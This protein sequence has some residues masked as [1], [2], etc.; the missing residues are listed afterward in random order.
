MA[1]LADEFG[2]LGVEYSDDLRD[3]GGNPHLHVVSTSTD[4]RFEFHQHLL[5]RPFSNWVASPAH[6]HDPTGNVEASS[7]DLATAPAAWTSHP[8]ASNLAIHGLHLPFCACAR[9]A[10]CVLHFFRTQLEVLTRTPK[11]GI[12]RDQAKTEPLWE[13]RDEELLDPEFLLLGRCRQF[14]AQ[15]PQIALEG[16]LHLCI[17]FGDLAEQLFRYVQLFIQPAI[18]APVSPI[19]HPCGHLNVDLIHKR[20]VATSRGH[21]LE[22]GACDEWAYAAA[23]PLFH[24]SQLAI[25]YVR[26]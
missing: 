19:F 5:R 1:S 11:Q 7:L 17:Q 20:C 14:H 18:L 8:D 15:G 12:K 22:I 2:D 24:T 13:V 4:S 3:V 9:Q 10:L 25:G 16:S 21:S 26:H 23:F 6:R